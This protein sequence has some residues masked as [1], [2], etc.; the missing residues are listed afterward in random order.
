MEMQEKTTGTNFSFSK[1]S[2]TYFTS[3]FNTNFSSSF[4][5]I[6]THS[7]IQP[8]QQ[9]VIQ[10]ATGNLQPMTIPKSVLLVSKPNSVIH[11][12]AQGTLQ[13]IQVIFFDL[14]F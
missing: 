3:K 13:A 10:T 7:V 14:T 4:S 2:L 9:S 12:T 6:K 11:T 5:H 8:N 1:A